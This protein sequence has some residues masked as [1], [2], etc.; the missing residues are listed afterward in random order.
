MQRS[1]SSTWS[2]RRV[3][4]GTPAAEL[5][6]ERRGPGNGC[7]GARLGGYLS[8]HVCFQITFLIPFK[9]R[10]HVNVLDANNLGFYFVYLFFVL[11][12]HLL[13]V[14]LSWW[15]V[16]REK[17]KESEK[18]VVRK[19]EE[20]VEGKRKS[21]KRL[22]YLLHVTKQ[23]TGAGYW[24]KQHSVVIQGSNLHI[25]ICR[26]CS[27]MQDVS[28]SQSLKCLLWFNEYDYISKVL[29]R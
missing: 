17:G 27:W 4:F 14:V 9:F 7:C 19:G 11:F 3:V 26:G 5:F 12:T 18:R 15:S 20:E 21:E 23:L 25:W 13:L 22:H 29:N 16:S 1:S 10:K 2:V 8:S 24:K 6:Q 28:P